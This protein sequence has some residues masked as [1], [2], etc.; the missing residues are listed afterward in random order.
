M[1][2]PSTLEVC[3]QQGAIQNHLYLYLT[4]YAVGTVCFHC[5]SGRSC[6]VS[7]SECNCIWQG[8]K[9]G[10]QVL[11]L[12]GIMRIVLAIPLCCTQHSV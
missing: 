3:S 2:Y 6:L 8:L 4:I 1:P 10:E 7:I 11:R 5:C 12:S 9:P